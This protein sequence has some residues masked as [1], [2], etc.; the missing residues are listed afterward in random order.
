MTMPPTAAVAR[1]ANRTLPV[2]AKL[3]PGLGLCAVI[4][5]VALL[6]GKSVPLVG[7]PLFAIA[8]GVVLTNT[9]RDGL[10]SAGDYAKHI[11]Q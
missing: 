7:A 1:R 4:A 2:W 10:M 6:A 11:G 3:A 9:A 8:I 5:A